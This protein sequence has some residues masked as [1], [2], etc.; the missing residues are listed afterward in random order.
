M[1]HNIFLLV[2]C[3]GTNIL[4]S[5]KQNKEIGAI[6]EI[7]EMDSVY[8]DL[9]LNVSRGLYKYYFDIFN[10][11]VKDVYGDTIIFS[12]IYNKFLDYDNYINKF[13]FEVGEKYAIIAD[14]VSPCLSSFPHIKGCDDSSDTLVLKQNN[15]IVK[16]PICNFSTSKILK[17]TFFVNRIFYKSRLDDETFFRHKNNVQKIKQRD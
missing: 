16:I 11:K 14:S 1:K 8:F 9:H 12:Y 6:V 7:I 15:C 4:L 10:I 17:E 13:G 5:Q 2:F 3:I